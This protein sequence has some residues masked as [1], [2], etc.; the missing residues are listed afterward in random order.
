M[1]LNIYRRH[2]SH[3]LGGRA[4]H[5]MSYEAD[6]LRRSW[7]TC[8]CPIYASGTLNGQF[9]RK[10]TERTTWDEAKPVVRGWEGVGSWDGPSNPMAQERPTPEAASLDSGRVTIADAMAAFLAV[11][12][13]TKIAPSTLRKYRTFCK[14][15]RSYAN[16]KGYIMLDQFTSA[17]IDVFYATWKLGPRA[18]G[19]A[20]GTLRAFFRFAAV[21]EWLTKSP[22]TADLKPPL[23]ANRVANKF[24]FTD[25]ELDRIYTACDRLGSIEW[26]NGTTTGVWTGEDA[27]DFIHLL[28]HTGY[29]ISDA[30]LFHMDRLRGNEILL[31]AQKN[32]GDMFTWIP[33][34]VRDRLIARA[35]THGQRPFIT[36]DS[37]RLETVTDL[38]RRRLNKV[39][40]LAGKFEES[41]TPHR[42]RHTFARMLLQR[43]V[44]VSDV[45]DLLGDDED[46]VREHYARWV[47]ERQ[48]RLTSI[49]R[50]AFNDIPRPKLLA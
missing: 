9:K 19:K 45:A 42:F 33:D 32:G 34:W 37:E 26:N 8:R 39:F 16:D 1:A 14:H 38:W 50:D 43:G 23:G 17:D 22:V 28:V 24:P 29:R 20:L 5:A 47:P 4:L 18:K 12:E 36:G 35:K 6:E 21:R 27:K 13:G 11:R 30:G 49:L 48:A 10:N 2:G 40:E 44:P 15:L 7:K 25:E 41:P 31:R 3:C 46:T